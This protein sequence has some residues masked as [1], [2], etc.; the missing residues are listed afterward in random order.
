MTQVG[1][2]G[3]RAISKGLSWP[4]PVYFWISERISSFAQSTIHMPWSIACFER[5]AAL[6][7][8]R[9]PAEGTVCTGRPRTTPTPKT[10]AAI[11]GLAA[12]QAPHLCTAQ[13]GP[14]P[15]LRLLAPTRNPLSPRPQRSWAWWNRSGMPDGATDAC[16]TQARAAWSE[17]SL[18]C[19]VWSLVW[20][21]ASTYAASCM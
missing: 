8:W 17:C 12:Y 2:V 1:Q 6:G 4:G 11:R 20:S 3:H 5:Q 7:L 10:T 9:S 15:A 16:R 19:V 14:V 13:T 21:D 18:V